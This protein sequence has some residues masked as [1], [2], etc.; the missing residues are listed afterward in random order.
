MTA[1]V[2][3]RRGRQLACGL[4]GRCHQEQSSP[5][6]PQLLVF[7]SLSRSNQKL[8]AR[9]PQME[10]TGVSLLGHEGD[11]EGWRVGLKQQIENI[12]PSVSYQA[13]WFAF[14]RELIIKQE[15]WNGALAYFCPFFC[16]L[17]RLLI[18]LVLPHVFIAQNNDVSAPVSNV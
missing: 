11:G 5:I 14:Y 15:I 2:A 10:V 7:L 9:D 17:Y 13:G 8:Q 4:A 16:E 3:L 12:Q 18:S 1:T 6:L